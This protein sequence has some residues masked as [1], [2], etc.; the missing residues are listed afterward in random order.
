MSEFQKTCKEMGGTYESEYGLLEPDVGG[1]FLSE[2]EAKKEWCIFKNMNGIN[3]GELIVFNA[4]NTFSIRVE[5]NRNNELIELWDNDIK[6]TFSSKEQ[7]MCFEPVLG[8]RL[9]KSKIC[10]ET[11]PLLKFGKPDSIRLKILPVD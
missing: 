6:K 8:V 1:E 11:F 9:P 7:M 10:V 3:G 4:P 2:H 5:D